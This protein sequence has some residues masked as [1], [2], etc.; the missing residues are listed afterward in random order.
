MVRPG[1]RTVALGIALAAAGGALATLIACATGGGDG[2]DA[3]P[4]PRP[5]DRVDLDRYVGVW[6]QVALI[7]NRFQ[8]RCARE[9]TA[10]YELRPDGRIDV[11]NRCVTEDGEIDEARG[12]ARVVDPGSNA[13]LEVSFFSILGWRPVWGDYWVLGLDEEYGWAVVGTPDRRYGWILS[14]EPGLAPAT[15]ERIDRIL[16]DRGYDPA[17]FVE[18]APS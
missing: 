2:G 10:R 13:R 18:E 7:P 11:V 14:R 9:T 12:L 6:H 4:P 5:V 1:A 3:K 8:S 17:D 15:R 16:V